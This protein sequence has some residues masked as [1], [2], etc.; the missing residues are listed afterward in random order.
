MKTKKILSRSL[1]IF[2]V[3][4]LTGILSKTSFASPS[5]GITSVEQSSNALVEGQNMTVTVNFED[6]TDVNKSL[7]L[8]CQLYPTFQ[9]F[10][11]IAMINSG[12]SYIGN[13]TVD[14]PLNST[15]GYHIRIIY[16]NGSYIEI[17]D[18][19]DFLSMDNVVEVATDV[20]YFEAGIVVE[21]VNGTNGFTIVII[22]STLLITAI[23]ITKR[24]KN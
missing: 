18:S 21:D 15:I 24:K 16:D 9:C 2:L 10:N 3:I 23:I 11:P 19:P 6:T 22:G 4:M 17:P 7:L 13:Y 1:P 8:V 20:F 5:Y 14:Q 12:N